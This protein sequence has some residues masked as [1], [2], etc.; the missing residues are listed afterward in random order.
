[1]IGCGW[2][3]WA[4]I[5][6]QLVPPVKN[7]LHSLALYCKSVFEYQKIFFHSFS[8]SQC[9][10]LFFQSGSVVENRWKKAF[11]SIYIFSK[12]FLPFSVYIFT[13]VEKEDFFLKN[14][15]S[16]DFRFY[17]LFCLKLSDSTHPVQIRDYVM[18]E[19]FVWIRLCYKWI[20]CHFN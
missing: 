14:K 16:L 7:V 17:N 13:A 3:S 8:V 10:L 5:L 1:M 15:T 4:V 18:Q 6:C 19:C 12:P 9:Q 20:S 2:M 11:K